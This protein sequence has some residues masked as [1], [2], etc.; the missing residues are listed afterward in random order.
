MTRKAA[1]P[2]ESVKVPLPIREMIRKRAAEEK[3]NMME[4]LSKLV[5]RDVMLTELKKA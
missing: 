2:R 5:A 4:Y 3:M 1:I